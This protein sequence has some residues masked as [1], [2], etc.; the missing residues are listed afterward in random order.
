[1]NYKNDFICLT[2]SKSR[3]YDTEYIN[4]NN[5]HTINTKNNKRILLGGADEVENLFSSN[6][7]VLPVPPSTWY[8]TRNK[9]KD[10]VVSIGKSPY[11]V[12]VKINTSVR[13]FNKETTKNKTIKFIEKKIE[14]KNKFVEESTKSYKETKKKLS[15]PKLPNRV[16]N[17]QEKDIQ[18]IIN[19]QI[20]HLKECKNKIKDIEK[21][22]LIN[23]I[24]KS[25]IIS[26]FS[27]DIYDFIN[28]KCKNLKEKTFHRKYNYF[29]DKDPDKFN[30]HLFN[31]ILNGRLNK[32]TDN[33]LYINFLGNNYIPIIIPSSEEEYIPIIIADDESV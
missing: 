1:M 14:I 13:N 2:N 21:E 19:A 12:P 33:N 29:I 25:K 7:H 15:S 27:K 20:I 6:P 3:L 32:K 22:E 30:L 5:N 9:V 31:K 28:K 10:G 23:Q 17:P 18:K 16:F 24:N 11:T 4:H 8:S 26:T